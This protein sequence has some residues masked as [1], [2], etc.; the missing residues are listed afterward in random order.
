MFTPI[1]LLIAGDIGVLSRQVCFYL[2]KVSC[3]CF[4]QHSGLRPSTRASQV[5][6]KKWWQ[7][8]ELGVDP[9]LHMLHGLQVLVELRESGHLLRDLIVASRHINSPEFT[10]IS[11]KDIEIKLDQKMEVC[12]ATDV[13]HA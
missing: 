13:S 11:L 6:L 2:D 10:P 8:P 4:S 5:A 9:H 7:L 3:K 1:T 12:L